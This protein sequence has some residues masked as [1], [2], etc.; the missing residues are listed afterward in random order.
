MRESIRV[1]VYES[2]RM[3]G[4]VDEAAIRISRGLSKR[5]GITG[6]DRAAYVD[7]HENIEIIPLDQRVENYSNG[8]ISEIESQ[9]WTII[10]D[11]VRYWMILSQE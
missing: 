9:K 10:Q 6:C 5:I 2:L 11:A 8:I 1:R 3:N 7:N 4:S